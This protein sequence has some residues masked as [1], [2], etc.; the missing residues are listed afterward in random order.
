MALKKRA[1]IKRIATL[2]YKRAE[3]TSSNQLALV[4]TSYAN[5][6]QSLKYVSQLHKLDRQYACDT[7]SLI[8]YSVVGQPFLSLRKI[9]DAKILWCEWRQSIRLQGLR[10]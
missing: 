7:C 2:F 1:S 6:L 8:L 9:I 10:T 3:S 4:V 5:S